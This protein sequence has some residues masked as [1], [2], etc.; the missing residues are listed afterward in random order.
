M[1]NSRKTLV[2]HLNKNRSQRRKLMA[3]QRT[4]KPMVIS[5][6]RHI[7]RILMTTYLVVW[8]FMILGGVK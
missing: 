5:R 3:I 2:L 4:R 8:A 7:G 1:S 6:K